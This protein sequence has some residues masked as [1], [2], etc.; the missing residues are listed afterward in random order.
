MG[1]DTECMWETRNAYKIT[2]NFKESD[3]LRRPEKVFEWI[4]M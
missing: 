3:N 1:R 4:L 2:E